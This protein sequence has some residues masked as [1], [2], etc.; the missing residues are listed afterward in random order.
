MSNE[1]VEGST[2]TG[3]VRRRSSRSAGP[4]TGGSV[5]DSSSVPGSVVVRAPAVDPEITETT[6]VE[7]TYVEAEADPDSPDRVVTDSADAKVHRTISMKRALLS[8]L[9]AVLV[10]GLVVGVAL[11]VLAKHS[12]QER[13]SRRAEYVQAARQSVVNMTTIHKDTA[14]QDVQ[15]ILDGASG[16]FKAEF[17]GRVDPFVSI[18]TEAKV[19]TDGSIIEAGLESESD[20]S[21]NVLVAA[22]STVTNAGDANPSPR[23][24]RLRVTITDTD[25]KLTTSK[26]EFVP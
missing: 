15:R 2:G 21:A 9:A 23:D 6:A 18:V 19:D 17:D 3:R 22:R 7:S 10:V 16:E 11:L 1:D 5:P 24:F 20:G 14:K 8:A 26:V 25:G 12:A 4:P 13:D